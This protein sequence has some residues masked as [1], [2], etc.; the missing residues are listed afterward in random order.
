MN[1]FGHV[2]RYA[3]VTLAAPLILGGCSNHATRNSAIPGDTSTRRSAVTLPKSYPCQTLHV[4]PPNC[5]PR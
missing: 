1:P 3:A 4:Q 5:P 2:A